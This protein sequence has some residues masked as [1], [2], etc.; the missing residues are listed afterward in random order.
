[1]PAPLTPG[2]QLIDA[3]LVN[4]ILS[5]IFSYQDGITAHAG[6]G[7][8]NA[9]KLTAAMN[10]IAVVATSGDSVELPSAL[11]NPNFGIS[12]CLVHNSSAAGN[13]DV[14]PASGDQINE[15]AANAEFT[16][17]A[18]KSALFFCA[19][20]GEWSAILTA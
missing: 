18:T 7:Q 19:H 14:Y 12:F 6:G 11:P 10:Y 1:M 13:L 4:Q 8:A 5:Q 16:V 20:K 9:V 15:G 2:L 3:T 17:N